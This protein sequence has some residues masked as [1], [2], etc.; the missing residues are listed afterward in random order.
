MWGDIIKCQIIWNYSTEGATSILCCLV[1][2]GSHEERLRWQGKQVQRGFNMRQTIGTWEGKQQELC[3]GIK[4]FIWIQ[5]QKK[6]RGRQK[7]SRQEKNYLFLNYVN[8]RPVSMRKVLIMRGGRVISIIVS[9][10]CGREQNLKE[11]FNH[12]APANTALFYQRICPRQKE[13]YLREND[14]GQIATL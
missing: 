2:A 13:A 14:E 12:A 7:V 4:T 9:R 8:H 6:P 5:L 11:I 10:G 3:E 1:G